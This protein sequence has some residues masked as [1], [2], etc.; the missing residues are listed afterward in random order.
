[1]IECMVVTDLEKHN[2]D[3]TQECMVLL[4]LDS[5]QLRI[6]LDNNGDF[7]VHMED[8]GR[9]VSAP[10]LH[11]SIGKE[12]QWIAWVTEKKHEKSAPVK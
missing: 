7:S 4:Q 12:S 3:S 5:G 1:M 9:L 11:G 6:K 10:D 8:R 2:H